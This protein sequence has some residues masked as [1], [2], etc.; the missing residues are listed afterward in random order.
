[1]TGLASLRLPMK[2]IRGLMIHRARR[3]ALVSAQS[4]VAT[5][6]ASLAATGQ[7]LVSVALAVVATCLAV[8]LVR[9]IRTGQMKAWN[10]TSLIAS[11]PS[12]RMTHPNVITSL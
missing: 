5:A 8:T 7:A 2:L 12:E 6:L 11:G 4:R 1:M 10:M 3:R 9:S